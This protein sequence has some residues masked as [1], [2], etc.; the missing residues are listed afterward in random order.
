MHLEHP[1]SL[2]HSLLKSSLTALGWHSYH[3]SSSTNLPFSEGEE[4]G[5]EPS[6]T[7]F[8]CHSTTSLPV[9]VATRWLWGLSKGIC[10]KEPSAG[11]VHRTV[12][13]HQLFSLYPA[14]FSLSKGWALLG[15]GPLPHACLAEQTRVLPSWS[16]YM[17]GGRQSTPWL[18]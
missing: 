12:Q 14:P 17:N 9:T 6:Q 7:C 10:L 15:S 3:P 5:S 18:H 2:P 4:F 1:R 16:F 8:G 11:M 13:Q